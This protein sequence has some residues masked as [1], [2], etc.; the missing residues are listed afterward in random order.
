MRQS[1][2]RVD[3]DLDWPAIFA[4]DGLYRLAKYMLER[5]GKH[6]QPL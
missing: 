2:E 3:E 4:S 6:R 1:G 5:F